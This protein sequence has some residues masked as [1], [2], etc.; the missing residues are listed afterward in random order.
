[1]DLA[2]GADMIQAAYLCRGP[3]NSMLNPLIDLLCEAD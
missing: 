3:M 2:A 1:M